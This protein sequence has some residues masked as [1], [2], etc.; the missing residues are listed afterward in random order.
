MRKHFKMNLET[1]GKIKRVLFETTNACN[2]KCQMCPHSEGMVTNLGFASLELAKKLLDDLEQ[3]SSVNGKPKLSFH[4]TG[5]PFLNKDLLEIILMFSQKEY[6]TFLHTNGILIKD[7]KAVVDS[8]L[9][10]IVFSYEC[11]DE[12]IYRSFRGNEYFHEIEKTIKEFLKYE[13]IKVVIECLFF[14]HISDSI[15]IDEELRTRFSGADF[16]SYYASDWRGTMSHKEYLVEP[17]DKEREPRV[18]PCPF[19][20]IAIGWDGKVKCCTYD[21]NSEYVLGDIS[22]QSLTEICNGNRRREFLEKIL[23]KRYVDIDICKNC[24]S[25]YFYDLK[26][27]NYE[28]N[29]VD[30]K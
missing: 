8:G 7:V 28:L 6:Y 24:K 11:Y 15:E 1:K 2:L 18:C 17:V 9:S 26:E 29:K 22:N 21:Y 4:I 14:R 25:P 5:E 20:N 27:R 3:F 12:Q 13:Q 10:E 16:Y 23:Q 19:D 30:V